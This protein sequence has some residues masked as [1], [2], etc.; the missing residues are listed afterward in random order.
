[1]AITQT[2]IAVK[3]LQIVSTAA[4]MI[5]TSFIVLFNYIKNH[6]FKKMILPHDAAKCKKE[7]DAKQFGAFVVSVVLL[8]IL[9]CM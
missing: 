1:M 6:F 8:V 9:I 5:A 4:I 2:P 3:I 7:K